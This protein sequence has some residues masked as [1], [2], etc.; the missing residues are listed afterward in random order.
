MVATAYLMVRAAVADAADRPGFDRWY[1]TEH[2]PDAVARFATSSP[3]SNGRA[4]SWIRRS[5]GRW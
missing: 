4:R 1:E 5:S 3:K 2:L